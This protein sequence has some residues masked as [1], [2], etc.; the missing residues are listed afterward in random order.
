MNA[1]KNTGGN[2]FIFS[3]SKKIYIEKISKNMHFFLK[4]FESKIILFLQFQNGSTI[5]NP[6]VNYSAFGATGTSNN[7]S[8]ARAFPLYR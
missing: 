3:N 4:T 5:F 1:L 6:S 8:A 2:I 7:L